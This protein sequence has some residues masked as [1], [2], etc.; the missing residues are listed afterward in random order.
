MRM[1]KRGFPGLKTKIGIVLLTVFIA[2]NGFCGKYANS[3][4]EIGVGAR[5]LGMG[6]AYVTLADD[7]TA[8][9]W[10]P[11]GLSYIQGTCFSAMYGPQFGSI[12]DPL[13]NYHVLG[14]AHAIRDDAVIGFHWI[15]L[16]VDDIPV[17]PEL[18]GNSYLDRFL[19]LSLRPNGDPD[20][21]I[22]DTEDAFFFSFSK[23][24]KWLVDFGWDFYQVRIEMPIGINIKWIK[25]TLGE[26]EADGIGVDAG[27]MCKIHMGDFFQQFSLGHFGFGLT[28]QDL[29]KTNMSWASNSNKKPQTETVPR[30]VKW[31]FAYS[32]PLF[33]D[34][35]VL[36]VAWDHDNRW[37]DAQHFGI[38]YT[39]FNR[40]AIRFGISDDHPTG[41]FGLRIWK[42]TLDYAFLTHELDNLHRMSLAVQF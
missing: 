1:I 33:K 2:A 16:S 9:Y 12:S 8:F 17:Y 35:H 13:G 25:Q 42:M 27:F 32:Q 6:S 37:E 15:R 4:L 36:R 26:G 21:Y 11:A 28:V 23:M 30:N 22:N 31:G 41:G 40:F 5:A 7:G 10:N 38:E 3:F 39:G 14:I 18:A 20:G 24:N 34:Q 29:T 19:D